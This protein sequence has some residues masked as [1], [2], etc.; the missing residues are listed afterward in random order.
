MRLFQQTFTLC[1][2]YTHDNYTGDQKEVPKYLGTFGKLFLLQCCKSS[3]LVRQERKAKSSRGLL[4]CSLCTQ[5][6]N[7][8]Q[9]HVFL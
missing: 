6:H 4:L 5:D 2:Y 9:N 3:V 8:E 1:I 7:L